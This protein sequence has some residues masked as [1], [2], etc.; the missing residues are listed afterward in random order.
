MSEVAFFI[1]DV[2]TVKTLYN[3]SKYIYKGREYVETIINYYVVFIT[4][5]KYLFC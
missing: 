3:I 5:I 1:L 2:L 4:H